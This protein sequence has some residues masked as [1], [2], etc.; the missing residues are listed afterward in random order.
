MRKPVKYVLIACAI[1]LIVF[2]ACNFRHTVHRA[3]RHLYSGKGVPEN[4]ELTLMCFH[5]SSFLGHEESPWYLAR[6]YALGH[7][8]EQ[9]HDKAV[10]WCLVG[11]HRNHAP[12]QYQLARYYGCDTLEH[13]YNEQLAFEWMYRSA[14]QG[15]AEAQYMLYLYYLDG[16]G[17]EPDTTLAYEWLKASARQGNEYAQRAYMRSTTDSLNTNP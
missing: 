11:A 6:N 7:T 12:T 4:K 3:G 16:T 2:G 17:V 9:D 5:L 1:G 8:V 13:L 10:E 14:V 15:Y